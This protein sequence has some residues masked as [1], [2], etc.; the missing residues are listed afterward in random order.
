MLLTNI[1][2]SMNCNFIKNWINY[3]T[4]KRREVQENHKGHLTKHQY[5]T[6]FEASGSPWPERKLRSMQFKVNT[7]VQRPMPR[8]LLCLVVNCKVTKPC[9]NKI[10]LCWVCVRVASCTKIL[11]RMLERFFWRRKWWSIMGCTMNSK[12]SL[13]EKRVMTNRKCIRHYVVY[14]KLNVAWNVRNDF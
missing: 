8:A 11:W 14:H 2:E 13:C 12:C 4:C 9:Y 7:K 10:I 1:N 6:L 5:L 3:Y